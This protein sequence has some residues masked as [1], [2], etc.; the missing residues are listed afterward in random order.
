M[1]F[2][3]EL[4]VLNTKQVRSD[5][6]ILVLLFIYKVNLYLLVLKYKDNTTVIVN[7]IFIYNTTVSSC[8]VRVIL[9]ILT[10]RA[11]LAED[12]SLGRSIPYKGITK[13]ALYKRQLFFLYSQLVYTVV[14]TFDAVWS[15]RL[16]ASIVLS[17]ALVTNPFLAISL[18]SFSVRTRASV[19]S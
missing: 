18:A 11:D 13:V 19:V 8:L 1:F 7:V 9:Q 4:S 16:D 17:S 3:E 15:R 2:I 6:L 10:S 12:M 5:R 14:P